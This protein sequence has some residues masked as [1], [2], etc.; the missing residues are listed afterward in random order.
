MT[1]VDYEMPA[2]FCPVCHYAAD[3]A[4]CLSKPGARPKPG[5]FIVCLRC[6]TAL[7]FGP[8][9]HL[10]KATDDDLVELGLGSTR[11][12]Q[13]LLRAQNSIAMLKRQGKGVR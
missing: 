1:F 4:A 2:A 6:A 11:D 8:A 10:L 5:D 13:M 3:A 7:W 12:Y 9:Y